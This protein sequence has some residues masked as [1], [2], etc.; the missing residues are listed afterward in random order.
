MPKKSTTPTFADSLTQLEALAT[1]LEDSETTLEQSL[2]DFEQGV[3]LIRQAEHALQAAEQKVQLLLE[4]NGEP[5]TQP[6][7]DPG[8]AA[9]HGE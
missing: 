1:R 9:G 2:R 8:E 6:F 3:Q 4:K 5:A 7:E